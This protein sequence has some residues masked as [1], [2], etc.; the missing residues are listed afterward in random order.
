MAFRFEV[1]GPSCLPIT[2]TLKPEK[3]NLSVA[4]TAD[5]LERIETYKECDLELE[6]SPSGRIED[7]SGNGLLVC[8]RGGLQNLPLCNSR[9]GQVVGRRQACNHAVNQL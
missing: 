2:R 1:P 9:K 6:A 4:Y 7:A 8:R 3:R 5:G